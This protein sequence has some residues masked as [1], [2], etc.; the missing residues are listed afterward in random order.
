M[1]WPGRGLARPARLEECSSEGRELAHPAHRKGCSCWPA[2]TRV[3]SSAHRHGRSLRH[4]TP[5][6]PTA[7]WSVLEKMRAG[8]ESQPICFMTSRKNGASAYAGRFSK[9]REVW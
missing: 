7:A 3:G 6:R 1:G 9:T 8:T 4:T 2:D 5:I